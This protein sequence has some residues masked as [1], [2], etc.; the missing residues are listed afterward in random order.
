LDVRVSDDLHGEWSYSKYLEA[1]RSRCESPQICHVQYLTRKIHAFRVMN[2]SHAP[3]LMDEK[4]TLSMVSCK[5]HPDL[6]RIDTSRQ[7]VNKSSQKSSTDTDLHQSI[8]RT[9]PLRRLLPRPHPPPEDHRMSLTQV[10]VYL[11]FYVS[12]SLELDVLT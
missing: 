11:P 4:S 1:Q 9:L 5:I 3:T 10:S 6:M 7:A 8:T 2:T 12:S